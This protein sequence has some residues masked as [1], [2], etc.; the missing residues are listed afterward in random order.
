M[1]PREEFLIAV[2]RTLESLDPVLTAEELA[3]VRRVLAGAPR[4]A[5]LGV[6]SAN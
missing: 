6:L 1:T 5:L 4:I 3:E 2:M